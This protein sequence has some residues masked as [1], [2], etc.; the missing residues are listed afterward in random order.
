MNVDRNCV[1]KLIT[2]HCHSN[3][4]QTTTTT[5]NQEKWFINQFYWI[6][7][8]QTFIKFIVQMPQ[9]TY[10][11]PYYIRYQF[12]VV[13]NLSR[14]SHFLLRIFPEALSP[15][16]NGLRFSLEHS[17]IYCIYMRSKYNWI[18]WKIQRQ[19][20]KLFKHINE[21]WELN[22]CS[23]K[24]RYKCTNWNQKKSENL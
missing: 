18:K 13:R 5:K 15:S 20:Y 17:H 19:F 1:I 22:Y 16:V 11:K 8:M 23:K 10:T 3:R 12:F 2:N 4:R 6:A 21:R 24:K 9:N 7:Q 14:S